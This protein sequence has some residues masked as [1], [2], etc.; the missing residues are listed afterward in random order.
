[1]QAAKRVVHSYRPLR[2][3]A[4]CCPRLA[5]SGP[6]P[7]KVPVRWADIH[8]SA[9]RMVISRRELL[10]NGVPARTI[11]GR[12]RNGGPW[13][14]LLPGVYLMRSGTP[15]RLQLADG[16]LRYAGRDAMI[17]GLVAAHMHGLR[18]V[19]DRREVHVLVPDQAQPN[20]YGYV[21]VERTTRL[22][23]PVRRHNL[24]VAPVARAVLDGVRR[25]NDASTVQA[26]LAE[27]VQRGFAS[28]SALLSELD[29]GCSRG[30]ALPRRMLKEIHSGVRSA[31]EGD[32]FRLVQ[33]SGLPA[34]RWNVPII[35]SRGDQLAVVDGWFDEVA[36]AWEID[37]LEFHL[38][39]LDY[40]NTLRRH[41]RLV[42]EGIVVVHTVPSDLRNRPKDVI[43][44]LRAAYQQ[45]SLRPRPPVHCAL[46]A[47]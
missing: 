40:A 33:R 6:V 14:R 5:H 8:D 17:T 39:P 23:I 10:S 9:P 46:L 24:E 44:D 31:S 21:I 25:L 37:S 1:M 12:A 20:S 45:A 28:P 19:P 16:A 42:A 18:R 41:N 2:E 32:A 15:T 13:T 35:G 22:P 43:A 4:P 47:A 38:S 11:T 26:L 27:T 34:P 30:S 29:A 36:L 3:F 7:R